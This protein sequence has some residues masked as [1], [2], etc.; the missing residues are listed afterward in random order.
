[1]GICGDTVIQNEKR[2]SGLVS[3]W[4]Q[5]KLADLFL[6]FAARLKTSPKVF[7][8]YSFIKHSRN[9]AFRNC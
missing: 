9:E 1:M 3:M 4:R 7:H 5:E 8:L 2:K 6:V